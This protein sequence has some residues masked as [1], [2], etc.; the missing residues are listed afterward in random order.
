MIYKKKKPKK[1]IILDV[2]TK[3]ER[4]KI[5]KKILAKVLTPKVRKKDLAKECYDLWVQCVKE[6]AGWKSELS[7]IFGTIGKTGKIIGLDAHHIAGKA[8]HWLRFE[9]DNGISLITKE[10]IFGIHSRDPLVSHTAMS[11]LIDYIGMERWERLQALRH[12]EGK[13]DLQIVK[14][15]LTTELERIKS[16]MNNSR[17]IN[18]LLNY[19]EVI[20]T[21]CRI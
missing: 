14:Q 1:K 15:N 7:G 19:L 11:K 3:K 2:L 5:R 9:L 10:H 20:P 13:P 17:E 12:K 16:K 6:R 18:K 21:Q 4:L 8:N